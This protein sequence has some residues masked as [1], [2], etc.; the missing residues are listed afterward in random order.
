MHVCLSNNIYRFKIMKNNPLNCIKASFIFFFI[1]SSLAFA[2]SSNSAF[3]DSLPDNFA[4]ALMGGQKSSRSQKSDSNNSTMNTKVNSKNDSSLELLYLE[5][6]FSP[7][8]D[9]LQVFGLD[10]F[11]GLQSTYA[12]L[13]QFSPPSNYVLGPGDI[14]LVSVL[15][16]VET[17]ESFQI[18]DD[19]SIFFPQLGEMQ[20]AGKSLSQAEDYIKSRVILAYPNSEAFVTLQDY[21]AITIFISGLAK[22]PGSYTVSGLS[23][24]TNFLDAAGGFDTS[25][26]LREIE[27]YRNQQLIKV[28]DLYDLILHGKYDPGLKLRSGDSILI[29]PRTKSVSIYG[30]VRRPAIY[31]LTNQ[32]SLFDLIN[33]SLG[34][35]SNAKFNEIIVKRKSSKGEIIFISVEDGIEPLAL[36]DGDVVY[37][38]GY[39]YT[40]A[41]SV[42][43]KGAFKT[44]G[45]FPF[46][47]ASSYA[48]K[49]NFLD[50][51]YMG[52]VVISRFD[53]ESNSR[54]LISA[55]IE[56]IEVQEGDILYAFTN[57]DIE[58][59]NS[60]NLKN[61][62]ELA[63]SSKIKLIKKDL[64]F[65]D[66]SKKDLTTG[67][68][69]KST[70]QSS[71]EK[72]SAKS[73]LEKREELQILFAKN[74]INEKCALFDYL[75]NEIYSV[76]WNK[77]QSINS[78]STYLHNNKSNSSI[79]A[80][81]SDEIL[82][83]Q[84]KRNISDIGVSKNFDIRGLSCP[85]IL[86]ENPELVTYLFASSTYIQGEIYKEGLYPVASDL[87]LDRLIKI[88]GNSIQNNTV[89]IEVYQRE[90]DSVIIEPGI[91]YSL[92][93]G[94]IVNLL[95][96][97]S[98]FQLIPIEI[99]GGVNRPGKYP[100]SRGETLLDVIERAGGLSD[101]AYAYGGVLIRR[102]AIDKEK[103]VLETIYRDILGS[104]SSAMAS[105]VSQQS[106]EGFIQLAKEFNTLEPTGRVVT[107]FDPIIL[108]RNPSKNIVLEAGDLLYIPALSSTVSVMGEVF[109]PVTLA[110]E[111]TRDFKDYLDL[112]G[113]TKYFAD[114]KRAFLLLPNGESRLI[115]QSLIS[116]ILPYSSDPIPPGSTIYIP[117]KDSPYNALEIAARVTPILSS[118]ALSA[119]SLSSISND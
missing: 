13:T 10:Y 34:L 15:G 85:K 59:L 77:L 31:E 66:D 78:Y 110:Y 74:K 65:F 52:I 23:D 5:E 32:E 67:I 19:G 20:L 22:Q 56:D 14:L 105:G 82:Q 26:S 57:K 117:R 116:R 115:K 39:N 118:F 36:Q 102:S 1:F 53:A 95:S 62:I 100:I 88:A 8:E 99:S 51:T 24:I 7:N 87:P 111:S 11:K 71:T 84:M 89:L 94:S 38:P 18:E 4:D 40:N 107:E 72:E 113:G 50:N 64:D 112:A 44:T 97:K 9:Q 25:A 45:S 30:A 109:S 69:G 75:N 29:K 3:M 54:Q 80:S 90:G 2:Q 86:D 98:N 6:N 42:T 61:F 83:E 79:D 41:T 16:A 28:Y 12:P 58:F 106:A 46:A 49:S 73:V 91:S 43:F 76:R 37:V 104:M 68:G 47:L 35:K 17:T 33:F 103:K 48:D 81:V 114:S 70:Q 92:Q 93:Q 108:K 21:R 101:D 55:L 96:A 27:L 60:Q 63:S 119:A